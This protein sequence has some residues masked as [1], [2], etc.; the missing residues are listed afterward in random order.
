MTTLQKY[1]IATDSTTAAMSYKI[2]A[3]LVVITHFLWILFL[4]FGALWGTRRM[5]VR[6]LHLSGLVFALIIQ[7]FDWYCPLTHIEVWLRSM[8]D[9]ALVYSGSFIIRYIERIVYVE[10]PRIVIIICTVFIAGFNIWVYLH[11]R[12]SPHR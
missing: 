1:F 12:R 7:V 3:D 9:P 5:T 4:V 8:H 10:V 2:L 11:G 6:I